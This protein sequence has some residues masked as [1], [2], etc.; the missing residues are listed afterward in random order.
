LRHYLPAPLS[1]LYEMSY[2]LCFA[3][4]SYLVNCITVMIANKNRPILSPISFPGLLF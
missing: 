3:S 2:I 1:D 4:Q